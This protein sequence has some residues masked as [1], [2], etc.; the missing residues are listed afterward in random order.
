MKICA[1]HQPNFFPWFPFFQKIMEA[2]IFVILGYCQFEK[3]NYQNRF[4]FDNKW[5]TIPVKHGKSTNQILDKKYI[6]PVVNIGK[7][8]SK[9]PEYSDFI[10]DLA[11]DINENLFESNV[12]IILNICKRLNIPVEKIT[13]DY[14]TQF[15]KT[16]RLVDICKWYGCDTYLSGIGA[17]KYL[18]LNLFSCNNIEVIFQKEQKLIKKPILECLQK[19]YEK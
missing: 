10:M 13:Y 16:E 11:V 5:Y 1:I 17:K 9:L 12:S 6:E 4:Y 2:D 3:N 19:C 8:I 14:P 18:D 15:T 7:I